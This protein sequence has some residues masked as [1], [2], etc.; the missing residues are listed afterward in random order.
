MNIQELIDQYGRAELG[1]DGDAAFALLGPDLQE[2][3]VEFVTITPKMIE[4]YGSKDQAAIIMAKVALNKLRKRILRFDLSF[5]F[6][7]SHPYG[8]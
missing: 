8:D 1:V 6:A 4:D 7:A 5:Y 3:E 2:G